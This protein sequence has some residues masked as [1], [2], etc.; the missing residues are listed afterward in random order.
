MSSRRPEKAWKALHS[1]IASLVPH[2][3]LLPPVPVDIT[4]PSTIKEAFKDASVVVS[5][6]GIMHG[7]SQDFETIQ[8]AGAEN[9]AVAARDAGAK[10]I[11]FSAI[12]ADPKSSIPYTRTKGLGERSVLAIDPTA[13]T[14]RPS[15][16]FGPEDDFFNVRSTFCFHS[17]IWVKASTFSALLDSPKF[18]PSSLFSL[19]AP[20][21]FSLYMSMIL[22]LL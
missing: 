12:G 20:L 4:K 13:T 2:N 7:T 15:I 8:W 17:S 18:F 14:I 10:L 22:L 5:L 3:C 19:E 6:V 21:A 11:H 9:V 1:E 16:V